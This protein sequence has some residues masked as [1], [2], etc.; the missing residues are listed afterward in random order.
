M[1]NITAPVG[2][3]SDILGRKQH[4]V[5]VFSV[6]VHYAV[7][8]CSEAYNSVDSAKNTHGISE[9][10]KGN[11]NGSQRDNCLCA[12]YRDEIGLRE[13]KTLEIAERK[14]KQNACD[15]Y[16]DEHYIEDSVPQRQD[17]LILSDLSVG[18]ESLTEQLYDTSLALFVI[19]FAL[20]VNRIDEKRLHHQEKCN[21]S[22]DNSENRHAYTNSLV[23]QRRF[24]CCGVVYCGRCHLVIP[25]N[26][27]SACASPPR[28]TPCYI[29]LLD[30]TIIQT[31]LQANTRI[32]RHALYTKFV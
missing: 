6:A 24:S 9:V 7:N 13:R 22:F 29:I 19:C 14:Q 21:N 23:V 16:V 32:F 3:L 15:D 28:T 18:S 30:Y 2:H 4:I 8:A 20:A 26:Q 31:Y 25:P 27:N 17:N 1:R 5:S 10:S 12:E 11:E